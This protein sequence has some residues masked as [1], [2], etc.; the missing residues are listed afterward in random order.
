MKAKKGKKTHSPFPL[1]LLPKQR[2]QELCSGGELFD[3][4]SKRGAYTEACAASLV[5]EL[6][7]LVA[8][9]HSKGVVHRDLKP[10][11]LLLESSDPGAALKAIDF[12]LAALVEPEGG[13]KGEGA[14]KGGVEKVEEE[15]PKGG[16][17]SLSSASNSKSSSLSPSSTLSFP[18]SASS[19]FL[20][21][22]PLTEL[23]GSPL[24]IAPEVLR[25]SYGKGADMWSVGVIAFV[26]LTG[27]APFE[28]QTEKQLFEEIL[29]KELDVRRQQSEPWPQ[30]SPGA[31]DFVARLL[32]RD[33][34]RRLTA[35]QA[36]K[37]PWLSEDTAAAEAMKKCTKQLD[38]LRTMCNFAAAG[39]VRKRAAAEVAQRAPPEVIE[40]LLPAFRAVDAGDA[41]DGTV[42]LGALPTLLGCVDAGMTAL[43]HGKD[44]GAAVRKAGEAAAREA[45]A[46]A[47]AGSACAVKKEFEEEKVGAAKTKTK[48]KTKT[49]SSPP[50]PPPSSSPSS[51]P[52]CPSYSYSSATSKAI[53][54]VFREVMGHDGTQCGCR[55]DYAALLEAAASEA[56]ALREETLA[57]SL[58]RLDFRKTGEL[59]RAQLE[60]ATRRHCRAIP[61]HVIDRALAAAREAGAEA[62]CSAKKMAAKK[63]RE[64]GGEIGGVKSSSSVAVVAKLN[65]K[66]SENDKEGEEEMVDYELFCAALARV[67]PSCPKA[68]KAA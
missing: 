67:C 55:V 61:Q 4:V 65:S 35:E 9:L 52:S 6:V 25:R 68:A 57:S 45:V 41:R 7:G 20:S 58:G 13:G 18:P 16:S 40:A 11:N 19:S 51:S 17:A 47:A 38:V 23:C 26:L 10:E 22:E 15:A 56:R 24:Y 62:S 60:A 43:K 29:N 30:L 36:L 12:G 21:K 39:T 53:L 42:S 64:R 3:Q 32:E 27:T 5:R 31:K 44:A 33:P 48:T 63:K 2:F 37:H 54:A 28:G 66:P 50:P 49:A 59:P 46:V 14:K 1:S 34:R 8:H